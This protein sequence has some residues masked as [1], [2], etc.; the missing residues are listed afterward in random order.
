M[1][2]QHFDKIKQFVL[3]NSGSEEDAKDIYQEA[4]TAVWRNIQLDKFQPENETSL[5][6]YIYQIAK[7]KWY[8]QLRSMKNKRTI[9]LDEEDGAFTE[10]QTLTEDDSA[11]IEAVKIKYLQLGEQC[12]ELLNLFY[13]K[14]ESMKQIASRF[15][16][17]EASAKNNKYRCL[18]KLREMVKNKIK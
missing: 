12:K 11:Y 4:F 16:W 2:V 9:G 18:Q 5:D 6:G 7:Y 13:F 8:D 3:Q 14:K 15:S 17:T 10:K 1:Y